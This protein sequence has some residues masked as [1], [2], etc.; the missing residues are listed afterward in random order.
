MK[1]L[2]I[3]LL[4][5]PLNA[6]A[7][8]PFAVFADEFEALAKEHGL[9]TKL[10]T[11]QFGNPMTGENGVKSYGYCEPNPV[12]RATITIDRP[13]WDRMNDKCKRALIF[14]EVGHCGLGKMHT[15][16]GIMRSVLNCD[17]DVVELFR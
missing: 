17:G 5:I 10:Y 12:G 4:L 7:V 9:E 8:S 13:L 15:K 2:F 3:C 11:I 6:W 16:D 1:T 14:H